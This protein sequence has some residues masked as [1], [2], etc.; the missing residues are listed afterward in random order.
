M[1]V[2]YN[3]E[4]CSMFQP[5]I[6]ARKQPEVYVH[7]KYLFT[8]SIYSP[9][10]TAHRKYLLTCRDASDG[11]STVRLERILGFALARLNAVFAHAHRPADAV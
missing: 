5:Q 3:I 1:C 10:G 6:K 11:R 9:E 2:Y 7:R 8:G 4:H